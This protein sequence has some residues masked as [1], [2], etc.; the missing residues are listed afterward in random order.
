M[1]TDGQPTAGGS[2]PFA[3]ARLA[4][5]HARDAGI[6]VYC[7]GLATNPTIAINETAI[8]NDTN[9]NPTSGGIAAI[10]GQGA[11]YYQ[12]TNSTQLRATFEKIARHLVQLVQDQ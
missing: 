3:Y 9:S 2:D 1:F 5:T 10:S 7:I 11:L 6:P 12:V 4:A 8:L